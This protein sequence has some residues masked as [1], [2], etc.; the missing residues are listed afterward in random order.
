MA[1]SGMIAID[2]G[3]TNKDPGTGHPIYPDSN[4]NAWAVGKIAKDTGGIA[5]NIYFVPNQRTRFIGDWDDKYVDKGRMEDQIIAY[6][7]KRFLDTPNLGPQT[8]EPFWLL[9][10]PMVKAVVKAMDAMS[11]WN[12]AEGTVRRISTKKF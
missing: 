5:A 8:D 11:E 3:T 9:R 2:G 7:W 12:V 6:T 1:N 10:Y 4:V